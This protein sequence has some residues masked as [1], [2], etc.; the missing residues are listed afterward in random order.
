MLAAME[1]IFF[2]ND[3]LDKSSW[4]IGYREIALVQVFE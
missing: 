1:S 2:E 3:V 4:E